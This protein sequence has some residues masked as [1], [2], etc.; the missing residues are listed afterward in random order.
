MRIRSFLVLSL[1]ISVGTACNEEESQTKLNAQTAAGANCYDGLS[2]RNGDGKVD[3]ADCRG[4]QGPQG[5]SGLQGP[6]GPAGPGPQPQQITR[7]SVAEVNSL[8]MTTQNPNGLQNSTGR[9]IFVNG[10]IQLFA[11]RLNCKT[12]NLEIQQANSTVWIRL[13]HY[14]I[15][16]IDFQSGTGVSMPVAFYLAPGARVR[17]RENTNPNCTSGTLYLG[18]EAGDTVFDWS[19]IPI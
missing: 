7:F 18:G 12:A 6:A 10:R 14:F 3:V 4:E 19:Y 13:H 8:L 2:D 1:I 9:V 11:S 16:G 17:V 5:V 15:Q